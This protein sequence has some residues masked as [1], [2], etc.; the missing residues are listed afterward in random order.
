MT[1]VKPA[2]HSHIWAELRAGPQPLSSLAEIFCLKNFTA[3]FSDFQGE[4]A[5]LYF[6]HSLWEPVLRGSIDLAVA[7]AELS[8]SLT[9]SSELPLW[10]SCKTA[11]SQVK[12][13]C[14]NRHVSPFYTL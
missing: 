3:M 2:P 14:E 12:P 11:N 1:G 4:L 13:N 8:P 7:D 6:D 5:L 9:A 10:L